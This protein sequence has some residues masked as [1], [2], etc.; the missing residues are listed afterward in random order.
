[1]N[2]R[3]VPDEMVY[4]PP[5]PGEWAP[6]EFMAVTPGQTYRFTVGGIVSTVCGGDDAIPAV[7]SRGRLYSVMGIIGKAGK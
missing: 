1:V 7:L 2:L 5:P 3:V 4:P 6:E